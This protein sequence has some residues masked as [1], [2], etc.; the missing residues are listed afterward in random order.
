MLNI[1]I[2]LISIVYSILNIVS[3][4]QYILH[5]ILNI[6]WYIQYVIYSMLYIQCLICSILN[7]VCYIQ[8]VIISLLYIVCYIQYVI[9]S[10]LYTVCYIPYIIF[11]HFSILYTIYCRRL[12]ASTSIPLQAPV[13]TFDRWPAGIPAPPT[14]E[15]P[16]ESDG[17]CQ[18]PL[19]NIQKA[20]ENA[21]LQL[22]H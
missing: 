6:V 21:Y 15:S 2:Q 5:S 14:E 16:V 3:F 17:Y 1:I 9:Y 4:I 22:I 7:I 13:S 10:V 8:Y 20:I 11:I 12:E 19:A 18:Y